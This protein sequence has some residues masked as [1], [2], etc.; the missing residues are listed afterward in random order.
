MFLNHN[1]EK[2]PWYNYHGIQYHGLAH[3]NE[4]VV[5]HI[6]CSLALFSVLFKPWAGSFN[7]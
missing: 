6:E 7:G 1:S 4:N 5:F 2:L 3:L